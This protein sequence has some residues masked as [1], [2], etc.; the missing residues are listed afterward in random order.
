MLTS[1][2]FWIGAAVGA[3]GYHLFKM[4]QAKQAQS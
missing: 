3:V 4:R 2:T 1:G